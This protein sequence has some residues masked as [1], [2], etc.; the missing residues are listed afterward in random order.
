[1]EL[2]RPSSQYFY[3]YY[4]DALFFLISIFLLLYHFF[5]LEFF[6]KTLFLQQVETK[7]ILAGIY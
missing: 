3:K 5:H 2:D 7:H 1:M 6:V 4:I